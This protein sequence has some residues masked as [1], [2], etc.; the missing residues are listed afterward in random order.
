MPANTSAEPHSTYASR[1]RGELYLPKS[2]TFRSLTRLVHYVA[3]RITLMRVV[4]KAHRSRAPARLVSRQTNP[5]QPAN[6][7]WLTLAEHAICELRLCPLRFR[8][9][10]FAW[11]RYFATALLG[12]NGEN[13]AR[14]SVFGLVFSGAV[15]SLRNSR[16]IL[17]VELLRQR[18]AALI[19]FLPYAKA[20]TLK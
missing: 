12:N 13:R 9:P 8:L 4:S 10:N 5:C 14:D 11:L 17:L 3:S 6:T 16:V 18:A 15:C 20:C 1:R 2:F 19:G 7:R